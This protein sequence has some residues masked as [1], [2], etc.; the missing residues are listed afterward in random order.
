MINLGD[1]VVDTVSGFSGVA[2]ARHD[3]LNGCS[4]FS[5]QPKIGKDGKLPDTASFDEPQ[6]KV[7]KPAKV[8]PGS[9]LTGGPE[10]FMPTARSE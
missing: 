9:R 3:Y 1:E 2:V 5:V 8:P 4:R 7:T 6:L 10:K